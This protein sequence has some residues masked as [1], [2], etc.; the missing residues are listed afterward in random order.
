MTGRRSSVF[1]WRWAGH[2][3]VWGTCGTARSE[4]PGADEDSDQDAAARAEAQAETLRAR[5]RK[6]DTAQN[7]QITALEDI[8]DSPAAPAMRARIR[9]RF[10]QLHHDR[11]QAEEQLAALTTTQ[12]KAADSSLLDDIPYYGDILP[13]LPPAP[14]ARLFAAIDLSIL[15]NKTTGRPP[16]P[17]SSPTPP[18]PPC[19]TSSTPT[20][21]AT[22]TPTQPAP[23]S[24]G[25]WQSPL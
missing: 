7:A 21:T 17:P 9:D 6:L 2:R 18:W 5:I 13:D 22:T 16:S 25:T 11:T 19:P 1:P 23:L 4:R 15:W 14:K 3:G 20:K 8:L 12:P 10:A 24:L